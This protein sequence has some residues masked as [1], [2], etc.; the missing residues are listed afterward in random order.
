MLFKP[1]TLLLLWE[2]KQLS[3]LRAGEV[4]PI[5]DLLD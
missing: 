1:I 5:T 4:A 2:K 3:Q